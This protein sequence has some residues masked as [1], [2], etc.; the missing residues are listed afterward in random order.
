[1]E[2]KKTAVSQKKIDDTLKK[3]EGLSYI[4]W[5]KVK[6][7]VDNAFQKQIGEF[8]RNLEFS[9]DNVCGF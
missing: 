1:M 9:C 2:D 4:E 3:L 7:M 8:Q 5:L 6:I